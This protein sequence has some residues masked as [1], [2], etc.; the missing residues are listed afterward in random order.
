VFGLTVLDLLVLLAYFVVIAAVG[1]AATR[2]VRNREDFLMG[3]RRFGKLMTIFFAFGAGTHAD[4]AVGVAAQSYKVG[5]AG[6]W[7]QG[8]NVFTLPIYWLLAPVFRRARVMTTADFFERRFGTGF[9]LLYA[10]FALFIM[11]VFSSVGLYGTARLVESLLGQGI[12]W[13]ALIPVIAIVAFFYSIAGG[14][15]AA[16]WNDFI[17]GMLTIVMSVLIIPFFW[18]RIGG[19]DGFQAALPDPQGAFRLVL[20]K[21]MTI[22]WIIMMSIN[23]LLSMVVQPHIMANVGSARSEMDSRVGFVGG[24]V[25]KRLMTIPW[26]LTGVMAI[27]MFGSKTI[28]ADHAFGAMA[29]ELLPAGF[30]GLMIACVFASIMDNLSVFM[31]SFAGIYTNSI[32]K[33]LF[34]QHTVERRLVLISRL[35][36]VVFGLIVI[37]LSYV[38]TDVPEAMRFT[39]KTVPLM[40]ISFFM[41]VWWRRANRYGAAG[42]FLAALTTML[43]A[44]HYLEWTGDAGLPK[45]VGSYMVVGVLAG[46][47]VSW[48]TTAEPRGR[49]DRFYLLLNTPIGQEDRLRAAGLLEIPGTGT[50]EEPA[51]ECAMATTGELYPKLLPGSNVEIAIPGR[52]AR[53]GFVWVTLIMLGLTALLILLAN[54]LTSG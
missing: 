48:L 53:V 13:K 11:V 37:P 35:A 28:A 25:L 14:L 49:L 46:V 50:F 15:I 26:A 17:Q 29:R 36:S 39:F 40:G 6:Y 32:H 54:W 34:P 18:H 44:Q 7:Y 43:I 5:F 31:I 1:V 42:S 10:A 21:D 45:L 24:M 3:G 8:M 4:S 19:L 41:A 9:M 22:W 33:K 27:A 16:V 47:V 38:F 23:S 30:A 52:N 20:Q 12:S 2:L 51:A